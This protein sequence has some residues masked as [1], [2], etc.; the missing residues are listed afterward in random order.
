MAKMIAKKRRPA[1]QATCKPLRQEIDADGFATYE[2]GSPLENPLPF[3]VS[4]EWDGGWSYPKD[5]MRMRHT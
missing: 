3:D 4:N 1:K 5:F 2:H